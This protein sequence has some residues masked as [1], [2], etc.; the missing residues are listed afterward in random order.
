MPFNPND[1]LEMRFAVTEWNQIIA[2]LQE[3]P[4]KT[5]APL[6]NKINLQA[7][8]HEREAQQAQQPQA[9]QAQPV[10]DITYTNGELLQPQPDL[11]AGQ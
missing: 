8:Q 3:G 1:E 9:A 7:A 5:V 4:Y 2:Q 6:I 11:Q 10:G